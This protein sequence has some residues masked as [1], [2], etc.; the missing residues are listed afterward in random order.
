MPSPSDV[1]VIVCTR[2]RP[3]YLDNALRAIS[4]AT[5]S[6]TE[7]IVVDS[8]SDDDRTRV[9][10]QRGGATYVRSERGLSIARNAG[11][12]ASAR[13]LVMFT[14]DDCLPTSG[15]IER[16][17]SGFGDL[18]TGAV[19]GRMLDH[20][21]DE[22]EPYERRARYAR[23]L[24]GLDAG[25]GAVMAFR[26]ELVLR[27]GGFDETMGAGQPLAGAEDLDIFVRIIRAGS[28]VVHDQRCI[29]RHANTRV[30]DEYVRLHRGY[31][32]GLGALIGKWL[33]IDPWFGARVAWRIYGRSAARIVRAR[34]RG[35][36]SAH[37]E[38]LLAGAL[39]GVRR[40]WRVPIVGER[41]APPSPAA[42]AARPREPVSVELLRILDETHVANSLQFEAMH[43]GAVIRLDGERLTGA[44]GALDR[45][46]LHAAITR[47]V[48]RVPELALR[49]ERSPAGLSAPAWVPAIGF[50]PREHVFFDDR[51]VAFDDV[52][53]RRLMDGGRG[54]LPMDRPLWDVTFTRL[55]DGDVAM[56]A[57]LH[58]ANGDAMWA[59]ATLTAITDATAEPPPP[60]TP[61]RAARPPRSRLLIPVLAARS[62][63]RAQPSA[64]AAWHEYWRKPVVK[65]AKR[66]VGRNLAPIREFEIRRRG[67]RDVHLPPTASATFELDAA[68]SVRRAAGL[69]GSLNDLLVAAAMRSVADD[70]LG[71]DVLVPVSRRSRADSAVRNHIAIVR[72]HAP[73][74]IGLAELVA[75][76]RAQVRAFAR[77]EHVAP[78]PRGRLIGYA[79]SLPWADHPRW[80]AGA[81]IRAIAVL[82]G[83][84][85]TDEFSV[86]GTIY[87]G[88]LAVTVTTRAEL[89]TQ[90]RTERMRAILAGAQELP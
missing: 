11:L 70:D 22:D 74:D 46:A 19:T 84:D 15:W 20:T 79:T 78:T 71:V 10:A 58:H 16:A 1:S 18:R 54:P 37:D 28:R 85:P 34:A 3:E 43:V 80:F 14:D 61:V 81:R 29:V 4:A 82:P 63:A 2:N 36:D 9:I 62:W 41:F 52:P 24:S 27:L 45:D 38:A 39:E 86:F 55:S 25:H 13:P 26:R 6:E 65:R 68:E 48:A 17:V 87:D 50:D 60:E 31:G 47:A 30:G 12:A 44:D 5:P 53:L 66:L 51:P 69:R 8:G 75:E 32:L 23:P 67:L 56:G 77:D 72:V 64:S 89:D 35:G 49:I 7:V 73:P 33:R 40:T 83:G 90:R 21:S 59:F 42:S 57:R 76:V 88:S